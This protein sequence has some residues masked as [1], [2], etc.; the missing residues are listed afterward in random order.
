MMAVERFVAKTLELLQEERETEIEETRSWQENVSVKELQRKGVCLMKLQASSQR[1]GLYGRLLVTFEPRKYEATAVLPSNGFT[2]G[3]ILGL[4]SSE[5]IS[6]SFQL[7]TGVVTRVTVS[8]ISVAFDE[9]S[10]SLD[11]DREGPYNLLKLSNDVTYKRIKNA[12]N[13][14]KQYHGGNAAHLIGVLF[15]SSE[16]SLSQDQRQLNFYNSS[17][18]ESQKAAVEFAMSQRELA[19]IHGPP[20]TGKTTTVVEIVLQ[21]VKKGM[22]ILCCAPSNVAVDNLV[23]RLAKNKVKVL[24]LGH[25]AR[26][27]ESIQKHCLDAVLAH[28]DSTQIIKDIRTDIDQAFA[29][30]KKVQVKCE[31]SHLYGEIKS[32]RKELRQREE[33]SITQILKGADVILATNTGASDDGQLKLLPEDYFDLVVIDECTQA[34]EGSCWIPLLKAPKCLLAGDHKQ[35]PPTI[36][37]HNAA[38]KGLSVS[39]MERLIEKYGDKVVKMLTVQYRMNQAIMKWASE[40][41]YGGRLLAHSSVEAHLLKDLPGVS[42]I[43]ETSLPLLLIDTAGCGLFEQD[44]EDE[45]SKGNQGEADIVSLHVEAL[46]KAGVKAKDIAVITPYNLQVDMIKERLGQKYSDLEIKSVDGFQGR[47]KEVVVLSLVRSNRKGDVG[48]LAENRR[49][50]VAVTR[51][52]RHL[53][54][55]C[56]SRTICHHS[57]LKS[58]VDYMTNHGEVRTAFEY[59]EDIVPQNYSHDPTQEQKKEPMM[60]KDLLGQQ[61]KSSQRSLNEGDKGKAKKREKNAKSNKFNDKNNYITDKLSKTTECLEIRDNYAELKA[62][63]LEFINQPHEEKLDFPPSLNSHDRL[64]VHQISEELGLNHESKGEGKDRYITVSKNINLRMEQCTEGK[65]KETEP[66]SKAMID[67]NVQAEIP[68]T[69]KSSTQTDLK[70]LHFER[71]QREQQIVKP[72]QEVKPAMQI[73]CSKKIK[74]TEK[75][76]ASNKGGPVETALADADFDEL[77][78]AVVKADSVCAFIKCKASVLTIGQLCLHCNKRYCLSHHIPEVHGCGDKAKRQA[79]IR[80]SREGVVYAGSGTKDKSLDPVKKVHLQRKLDKKL[81]DLSSQRK[82][83]KKDKD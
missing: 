13:S 76:K 16:P 57:F 83:K 24:R 39:L 70:A 14:L 73:K 56:D 65:E 47:E 17:L 80:I 3:D 31:K 45:Q 66:L 33:S 50:N 61:G 23:E 52:R 63:I 51:A 2:P 9:S 58:L 38:A 4:Y 20:G 44:V 7:A 8:S 82:P 11:L 12:L 25:P 10:D 19:I 49:I 41:M 78:A 64:L 55:V 72:N 68:C 48:F 69:L 79:R 32:L 18:D 36:K 40:E 30:M 67:E 77:I 21:A 22:K 74:N 75:G 62:K 1:T 60:N 46:I 43:E 27:L 53:A 59:L 34:L 5:G 71:L 26:L 54:V 35:L 81:D 28:S 29:K 42:I 37:S 15:G 6:P